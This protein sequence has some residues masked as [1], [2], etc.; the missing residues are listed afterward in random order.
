MSNKTRTYLKLHPLLAPVKVAVF[1]LQKDEELK[2][3][4]HGLY[5]ELKNDLVCEFDDS[6]NIG[7]MYRRQDEIGTPYCITAD[8]QSITDKSVTLR[9]RDT[10]H[11]KRVSISE[12]KQYIMDKIGSYY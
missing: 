4:A 5:E 10:T 1:P 7:Q 3:I 11:Q 9:E 6:G 12:V 8:Y 2:K